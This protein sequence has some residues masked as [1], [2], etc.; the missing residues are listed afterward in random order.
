MKLQVLSVQP[1]SF[2]CDDGKVRNMYRVYCADATGAV[3]SVYSNKP[4]SIGD[5][6]VLTVYVNKDGKFS[7]RI[8]N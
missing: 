6:V 3:G 5:T 4:V 1:M 8:A 7:V 2:K